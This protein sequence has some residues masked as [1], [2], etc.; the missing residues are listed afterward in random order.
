M[1]RSG[2]PCHPPVGLGT[3]TWRCLRAGF[4]SIVPLPAKP[5]PTYS[6]C[7]I[8]SQIFFTASLRS[9]T[10]TR[11]T[12]RSD[13]A[14]MKLFD[15]FRD[16]LKGRHFDHAP[17]YRKLS[18]QGVVHDAMFRLLNV[19]VAPATATN[20][21]RA[22]EPARPTLSAGRALASVSRKPLGEKSCATYRIDSTKTWEAPRWRCAPTASF[23]KPTYPVGQHCPSAP[24]VA[25][26]STAGGTA[27]PNIGRKNT[28]NSVN[29]KAIATLNQ[30][31]CAT[32]SQA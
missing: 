9:R 13:V 7:A 14:R 21:C 8:S 30:L 31:G 22:L 3:T 15:V 6:T 24:S 12:A 16:W 28:R 25:W 32:C 18:G 4:R 17:E 20:R 23:W 19:A 10:T 27:K 26:P 1:T 2:L 29:I 5:C 11:R